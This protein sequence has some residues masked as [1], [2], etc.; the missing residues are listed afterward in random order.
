MKLIVA[1]IL[2]AMVTPVWADSAEIYEV[3]AGQ[4]CPVPGVLF[5]G[6]GVTHLVEDLRTARTNAA[7]LE[8]QTAQLQAKTQQ[9]AELE[10]TIRELKT[11]AATQDQE[12]AIWKALDQ[13]REVF[14]QR[15][16]VLFDKADKVLTQSNQALDRANARIEQLEKRQLWMMILGPLG[17]LIGVVAGAAL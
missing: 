7:I 11:Q 14:E 9:I 8:T 17:V 16:N 3:Q 15:V 5:S 6:P 13:R 10:A 1:L 12:L 2:A 4:V